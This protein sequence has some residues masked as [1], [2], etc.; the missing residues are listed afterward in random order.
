[1]SIN[2]ESRFRWLRFECTAV[3]IL[4][5]LC[6]NKTRK[7]KGQSHTC[8]RWAGPDNRIFLV[9]F[10]LS[11]HQTVSG[12]LERMYSPDTNQAVGAAVTKQG[13]WNTVTKKC[14]QRKFLFYLSNALFTILKFKINTFVM[15]IICFNLQKPQVQSTCLQWY[16]FT[17]KILHAMSPSDG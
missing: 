9:C 5:K 14:S 12:E 17:N 16:I 4:H 3:L 10:L 15:F 7:R 6:E 2:H 1:M 13:C 11:A 8:K